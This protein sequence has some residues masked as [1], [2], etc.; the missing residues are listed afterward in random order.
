MRFYKKLWAVWLLCCTLHLSAQ[1]IIR[2]TE[3]DQDAS[4]FINKNNADINSTITLEINRDILINRL[5]AAGVKS[6]LPAD[7][8]N[9]LDI[10]S[11]ALKKRDEWIRRF[12][13]A[14]DN[15]E[16]GNKAD[17]ERFLNEQG[18]IAGEFLNLIES[19]RQLLAYFEEIPPSPWKQLT[20]ALNKRIAEIKDDINN[21]PGYA[22]V[23]IR[24]GGWLMHNNQSTPLHFEG[25]DTNPLSEF[26]EMERWQVMPTKEQLD[27]L[28]ALQNA[29]KDDPYKEADLTELAKKQYLPGIITEL[30]NKLMNYWRDLQKDVNDVVNNLSNHPVKSNMQELLRFGQELSTVLQTK[31]QYYRELRTDR[32]FNLASF[33][34]NV[35]KDVRE[36]NGQKET[37][38]DLLTKLKTGLST[39]PD[40]IKQA[41]ATLSSKLQSHIQ[42]FNEDFLMA[43]GLDILTES[44]ELT[45][46]A[47]EFTEKVRS[48]SLKDFPTQAS[49]DLCYAGYRVAGDKVVI[50]LEVKKGELA[51]IEEKKSLTLYR[52][53]PHIQ[54]TVGVIFAHP[55]SETKITKD[56]QMAPYYNLLFKGILGWSKNKK[57]TSSIF[58]TLLDTN[59]GLHVSSPD[60]DKDDVPELG[61]GVVA[62]TFKDYLQVGWAYNVFIGKNY[63]FFGLRLPLPFMNRSTG[64]IGE[65][66]STP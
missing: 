53:T 25:L 33:L 34:E 60:F 50:K 39:A 32:S 45:H 12:T 63:I 13:S 28:N 49:T 30:E 37:L 62:S 26:Y 29:I 2:I 10:F 21:S 65:N 44:Q 48:L 3:E 23:R 43:A 5:T 4:T 6:G 57:R 46:L 22:D 17:L 56:V 61:F 14:I 7:V 38:L 51:V 19:D 47:L 11:N 18:T 59:L 41:A 16:K 64:D 54:S 9:L 42:K 8:T 15:Y 66:A 1:N 40:A 36:I 55:L 31:V 20:H 35:G 27:Q 24:L 52:I 58:N